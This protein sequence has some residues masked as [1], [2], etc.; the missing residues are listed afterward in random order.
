MGPSLPRVADFP[1]PRARRVRAIKKGLILG[2]LVLVSSLV[3]SR[4]NDAK[5]R[6]EKQRR[7]TREALQKVARILGH[8]KACGVGPPTEKGEGADPSGLTTLVTDLGSVAPLDSRLDPWG[9]R[10][11]WRT[12]ENGFIEERTQKS[13]AIETRAFSPVDAWGRRIVYRAPGPRHRSGWDLFSRGEDGTADGS[14]PDDLATGEDVAATGS[15]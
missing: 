12:L 11:T 8:A 6:H 13:D 1:D 2:L 10:T 3:A 15:R 4:Y 14:L 5:A 7:D 9:A